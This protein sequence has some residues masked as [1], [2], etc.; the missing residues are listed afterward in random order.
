[1]PAAVFAIERP[2]PFVLFNA[3]GT[4]VTLEE[5]PPAAAGPM[6]YLSPHDLGALRRYT[7]FSA[8]ATYECH[9]LRLMN[10]G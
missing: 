3:R 5:G 7:F 2:L 6:A 9:G 10:S 1:M 8:I 4:A